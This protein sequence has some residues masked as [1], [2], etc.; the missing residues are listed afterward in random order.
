MYNEVTLE[1][2]MRIFVCFV[3]GLVRFSS[4]DEWIGNRSIQMRFRAKNINNFRDLGIFLEIGHSLLQYFFVSGNND[5]YFLI[6]CQFFL[7]K[8]KTFCHKRSTLAF[9]SRKQAIIRSIHDN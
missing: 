1:M 2:F 6:S 8:S 5:E 4:H 7:A 9:K 3:E